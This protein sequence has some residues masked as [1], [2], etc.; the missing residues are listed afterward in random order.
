[1]RTR[2]QLGL[3]VGLF[4]G[5]LSTPLWA[6]STLDQ[7]AHQYTTPKTVATF[8]HQAF[9]F[10]TDQ[11][12]FHDVEYWQTPQ[13]FLARHVG[14][15][16]DYALFARELLV[17]NGIEAYVFSLFGAEGYAHTVCI[18]VDAQGRYNVINQDKLR[19]YRAKTLS[20]LATMLYPAWTFGGITEQAG[21]RGRLVKEITN[22]HP[23]SPLAS[24]NALSASGFAR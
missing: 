20:A 13:E 22:P 2:L 7:L 11:E 5:S 4:L 12:L 1:M 10:K 19:L 3:C 14:D 15:C 17:R 23:V 8:L 16:E 21:A 18:Y 24:L 6:E 9:K